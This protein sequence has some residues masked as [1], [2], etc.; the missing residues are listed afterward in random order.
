MLQ[1][2]VVT[3]GEDGHGLATLPG[4]D[5]GAGPLSQRQK[6]EQVMFAFDVPHL[7]VHFLR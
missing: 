6:P 7:G 2:W 4:H 5:D 1:V 3:L